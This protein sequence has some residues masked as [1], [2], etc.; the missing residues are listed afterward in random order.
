MIPA[1]AHWPG[2]ETVRLIGKGS[3]GSVY[4]IRKT[5]ALGKTFSAALKVISIPESAQAYQTL[6]L[7][8]M[9]E[10]TASSYCR[11]RAEQI[12]E[13]YA[14]LD[15]LK[16]NSHIVS[17]DDTNITAHQEDPGWDILIKME[18][19]TP[20]LQA[21]KERPLE[22][23]D[24]IQLGMDICLALD[25]CSKGGHSRAIIH[26]DIKPENLFVNAA[27][28]Y[29][30]GDFGVARTL[31]HDVSDMTRTGNL[32]FMAPEVY[33]MKPYGAS[34][35]QYSLGLVL[36]YFL[37]GQRLPFQPK[38][39]DP[40]DTSQALVK[41][42]TGEEIPTPEKGSLLLHSVI[43]KAI[44]CRPEDRYASAMAFYEALKECQDELDQDPPPPPPP[45][46]LRPIFTRILFVI[47]AGA[48]A[49]MLAINLNSKKLPNRPNT[50][51]YINPYAED[52]PRTEG[53]TISSPEDLKKAWIN[54]IMDFL[55][56]VHPRTDAISYDSGRSY[57]SIAQTLSDC[58]FDSREEN[59]SLYAVSGDGALEIDV[60]H[61]AGGSGYAL[62]FVCMV[63]PDQL[64]DE[65]EKTAALLVPFPEGMQFGMSKEAFLNA[66]GLSEETLY[67][68][69]E[70]G[71]EW[72][73]GSGSPTYRVQVYD[74]DADEVH[75][76]SLEASG[77]RL[78][79]KDQ[80]DKTVLLGFDENDR[81]VRF[82]YQ[83]LG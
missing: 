6:L 34:V 75:E 8:G 71:T 52:L 38:D 73:G 3:F 78:Q 51:Q 58:G 55:A 28:D 64:G 67:A 61:R 63:D 26:R 83:K 10:E 25:A 65:M 5:D 48:L 49:V 80:K 69:G 39:A 30:L 9:D 82:Y 44:A 70:E 74:A 16:G 1:N 12:A 18:L 14:I 15:E 31:E 53:D 7:K 79:Y 47:P 11:K 56:E 41:R 40:M 77:I 66:Y 17:Y 43:A 72:I 62:D 59:G 23:K 22:V 42:L 32:S 60:E 27:G 19:L 46:P 45:P 36:Y 21:H 57:A 24:V 2:W 13:E 35:D 68:L 4:E 54:A 50:E 20:L 76:G 33:R 81:L 29:K 37:N